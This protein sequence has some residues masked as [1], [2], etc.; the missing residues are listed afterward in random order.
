[1]IP[2]HQP[3]PNHTLAFILFVLFSGVA[4][5]VS[6]QAVGLFGYQ[7]PKIPI[8]VHIIVGNISSLLF[9]FLVGLIGK[10]TNI[11]KVLD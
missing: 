3:K 7:L 5:L 10:V 1:M 2:G 11:E 4:F 8:Y 9:A 6:Y